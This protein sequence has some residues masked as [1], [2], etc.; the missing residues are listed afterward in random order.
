MGNTPPLPKIIAVDGPAS[1]GKSSVSYAIA[2]RLN[3]V[4]VDTGAFYRAITVLA[5]QAQI[6]PH[7]HAR[8]VRLAETAHL[9]IIPAPGDSQRQYT[10]LA[11]QVDITPLL[12]SPEVDAHVSDIS[13]VAGVRTA[14]L[15]AQRQLAERRAVIMAGRD[16]GTIVLPNADL[17]IYID[18]SLEKRAERRY[19]Q[20]IAQGEPADLAA[21]CEGLRQRD[22]IDS[23]RDVAP[24]LKADDAI[25]LDTSNM[26][27]DEAVEAVLAIIRQWGTEH[28]D[29]AS[30]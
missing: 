30:C 3:Y 28:Q 9:D 7:D 24:L 6:D 27:F 8:L 16:I 25:Y 21:I 13:A 2:Q 1:S 10:V 12:H 5:L 20:R 15:N 22:A 26:T 18:A 14:L 23:G 19:Q 17:K 11:N 4:F 29:A